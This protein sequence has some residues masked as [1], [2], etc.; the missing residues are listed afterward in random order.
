[1]AETPTMQIL[2]GRMLFVGLCGTVLFFQLLPLDARPETWPMPDFLLLLVVLWSARRPDYA[3]VTFIAILMLMADLLLQ[4]P[5]GLWAGLAVI[6]TEVLRRR[7]RQLRNSPFLLEWGSV[8][9]GII[10]INMV[11]RVA[12]AVVLLPQPAIG[13]TLIQMVMT[14]L[15]YPIV[16]LVAHAIFG[17][18]RPAPGE[19]DSFGHRL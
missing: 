14:I 5:P 18:S 3:P 17:V 1:M 2:T 15:A 10:A 19:T 4:R 7:S 16:V 13:L 9:A 11:N 6:F 8:A 12:M